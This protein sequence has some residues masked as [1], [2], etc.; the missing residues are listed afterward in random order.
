MENGARDRITGDV[1]VLGE[2]HK[3]AVVAVGDIEQDATRDAWIIGG[4]VLTGVVLDH[5][6]IGAWP[7]IQKGVEESGAVESVVRVPRRRS[8][9]EQ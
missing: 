8:I 1:A 3:T 4:D 9:P 2:I 6:V 5:D 7:E